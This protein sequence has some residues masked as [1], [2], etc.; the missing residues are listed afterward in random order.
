[1]PVQLINSNQTFESYYVP[2]P[3][4]SS[5]GNMMAIKGCPMQVHNMSK[6]LL[7]KQHVVGDVSIAGSLLQLVCK[8]QD[9]YRE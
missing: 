7:V 4:L 3:G 6:G 2:G 8:R 5:D 9:N 1:M